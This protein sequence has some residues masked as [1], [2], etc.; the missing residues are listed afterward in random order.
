MISPYITINN[1]N[2]LLAQWP[3]FERWSNGLTLAQVFQ[4][5]AA[6]YELLGAGGLQGDPQLSFSNVSNEY[7]NIY[8]TVNASF[9]LQLT[10]GASPAFVSIV[11]NRCGWPS[12]NANSILIDGVISQFSFPGNYGVMHLTQLP[13]VIDFSNLW[14]QY[15]LS[16][17]YNNAAWPRGPAT[18]YIAGS[19]LVTLHGNNKN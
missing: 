11:N 3:M 9:S 14:L 7:N 18:Y 15:S 5:G 1:A 10:D 19:F 8:L 6:A 13:T 2:K 4:S 12:S 17:S 16:Q